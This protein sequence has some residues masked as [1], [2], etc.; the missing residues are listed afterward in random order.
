MNVSIV[1]GMDEAGRGPLAGPVCVAS[2]ILPEGAYLEKIN[3]L[4]EEG[5]ALAVIAEMTGN[6]LDEHEIRRLMRRKGYIL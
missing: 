2:V 4:Y 5:F 1:C 6:V 3:D